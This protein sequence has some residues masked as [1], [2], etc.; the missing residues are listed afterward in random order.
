MPLKVMSS[1][2]TGTSYDAIQALDYAVAMGSQISN[3][4]YSMSGMYSAIAAAGDAGHIFVVSAGNDGSNID[5]SAS[6]PSS[7]DLENIISVAA[8]D[9][10]DNKASWSNYGAT[11]VNLG[12]PGVSIYSTWLGGGYGTK[13]GTSTAAPHVTGTVALVK[14][15]RPQWSVSQ[16]KDIVLSSVDLVPSLSGKTV[17]GGRLNAAAAVTA[18]IPPTVQIVDNGDASFDSVGVWTQMDR[19]RL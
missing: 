7:Y 5:I 2:G 4:S 11:A 10:N 13:S 12:A 15:L 16:V 19:T 14:S 17:T 6:Y 18:A 3:N 8:T 9:R 1:S